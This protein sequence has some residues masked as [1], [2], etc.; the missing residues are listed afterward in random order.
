MFGFLKR[1]FGGSVEPENQPRM[2]YAPLISTAEPLADYLIS[3]RKAVLLGNIVSVGSIRYLY[4]MAF[5]DPDGEPC[6][7]IASEVNSLQA[8][9]G[10]ASHF[11]GV[12]PG[13]GHLNLGD[14][15][16]WANRDLFVE[17]ALRIAPRYLSSL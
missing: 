1:L 9:F 3:G 17:Q 4:I 13:D 10:G 11:L 5:Y 16:D 12:F 8:E 2:Q 7:F 14:S 6:L 15:N